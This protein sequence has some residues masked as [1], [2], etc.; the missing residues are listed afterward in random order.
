M[1]LVDLLLARNTLKFLKTNETFRSI[2]SNI[3]SLSM[4][5]YHYPLDKN[6][7]NNL[8]FE[9][10]KSLSLNGF[11]ESVETDLFKSFQNLSNIELANLDTISFIHK[12]GIEWTLDLSNCTAVNFNQYSD[13][14]ILLS[15]LCSFIFNI[16]HAFH[17]HIIDPYKNL[18]DY[19][20]LIEYPALKTQNN[21]LPQY[22]MLSF[23]LNYV[24]FYVVNTGIEKIILRKLRHEMLEK[25]NR[26]EQMGPPVNMRT[27]R[28]LE[29][30]KRKRA[31]SNDHGHCE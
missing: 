7:L 31:A 21:A 25:R 14:L 8:V 16:G 17:Y 22:S 23:I 26:A 1:G 2:N 5:G 20:Y 19:G 9:Q 15:L 24:A 18:D 13:D 28:K 11:I 3:T 27:R 29:M 6:L 12:I 4:S 10:L 30:D